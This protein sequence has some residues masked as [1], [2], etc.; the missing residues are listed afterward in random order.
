MNAKY[1]WLINFLQIIVVV[2]SLVY[3]LKL[4]DYTETML[5]I[6]LICAFIY[7]LNRIHTED[8]NRRSKM[9]IAVVAFVYGALFAVSRIIVFNGDCTSQ[10]TVN[11]MGKIVDVRVIISVFPMAILA[12]LIIGNLL[13]LT[14]KYTFTLISEVSVKK[15]YAFTWLICTGGIIAAWLPHLLAFYPGVI[16]GDS[17]ASIAQALGRQPLDN[18]FP[19]MYTL[20]IKLCIKVGEGVGGDINTGVF[21]YSLIQYIVMA[22][23]GGYVVTWLFYNKVKR[24][25][26]LIVEMFYA[27]CGIFAGYAVSMWKD[28]LFGAMETLLAILL[29]DN[30]CSGKIMERRFLIQWVLVGIFTVFWRNNGIYIFLFVGVAICITYWKKENMKR[31][32][33]CTVLV[34]VGYVLVTGPIYTKNNI[35]KDTVVESMAVPIQQVAS[36]VVSDYELTEEQKDFIFQILPEEDWESYVPTLVDRIK[37]H[38]NFNSVF[39]CGHLS[40]FLKIWAQLL[41][42]NLDRYI[43]SYL[44]LTMGFWRSGI[45]NGAGYFYSPGVTENEFGIERTNLLQNVIDINWDGVLDKTRFFVCSGTLVWIMLMSLL[46]LML[47]KEKRKFILVLLPSIATWLTLMIATPIAFSFRYIFGLGYSLPIVLLLPF[48]TLIQQSRASED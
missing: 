45:Q 14:Q 28:P 39:F 47:Q 23:I 42:P 3:V 10:Y 6:G 12:Y 40:E 21:I 34:A 32:L 36:V 17:L 15:K 4:L 25:I 44:M 37:F 31:F 7:M 33:A 27:F 43:K 11:Y 46:F 26:C 19:I 41:I 48:F 8:L 9:I 24:E 30:V 1:D 2:N 5:Y 18:H 38:P 20:F 29:L 35:P 22:V 16:I 13:L